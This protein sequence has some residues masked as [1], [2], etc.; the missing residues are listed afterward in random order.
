MGGVTIGFAFGN[1]LNYRANGPA[2]VVARKP[3]IGEACFAIDIKGSAII[4]RSQPIQAT[5]ISTRGV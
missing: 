4:H 2:V 5:D 1:V 3:R